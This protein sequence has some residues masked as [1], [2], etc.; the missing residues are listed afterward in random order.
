MR[1]LL[2]RA[3]SPLRQLRRL[4]YNVKRDSYRDGFSYVK[5][6]SQNADGYRHVLF[7]V[8]L[9]TSEVKKHTYIYIYI[10]IHI[11]IYICIQKRCGDSCY[12]C[13]FDEIWHGC[14]F[15][16]CARRQR[17]LD[18]V[19]KSVDRTMEYSQTS[20][21]IRNPLCSSDTVERVSKRRFQLWVFRLQLLASRQ[22]VRPT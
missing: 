1:T 22:N 11:Y 14:L 7:H 21:D 6:V 16:S 12:W 5:L 2:R 17:R 9:G 18:R 15:S 19:H 4:R 8:L 3:P 20:T 10:Y 13:C